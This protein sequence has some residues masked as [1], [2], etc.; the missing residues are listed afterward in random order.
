MTADTAHPPAFEL[1]TLAVDPAAVSA[2]TRAHAEGCEACRSYVAALTNGARD[3]AARAGSADAFVEKI[4]L[5][6]GADDERRPSVV[7]LPRVLRARVLWAAAPLAAAAIALVL[8]RPAVRR[9]PQDDREP[10][11]ESTD[12]TFKGALAIAV[13]RERQGA[14][15]RVTGDVEV[16]PFDRIRLEVALDTPRPIAAGVLSDDG[17]WANLV[18]P[19]LLDGGTHFS[20]LS[21]R[22]DESPTDGV[23]IV[24]DPDAVARARATHDLRGVRVLRLHASK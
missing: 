9:S 24:G 2:S 3:F 16:R 11:A 12:T 18:V 5:R 15:E 4:A 8:L 1:E 17:A 6:A 20:E 19:T 10:G 22:F 7:P 23:L 21:V 13:I 14:Q